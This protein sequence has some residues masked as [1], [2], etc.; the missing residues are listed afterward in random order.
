MSVRNGPQVILLHAILI[1]VVGAASSHCV[2]RAQHSRVRMKTFSGPN[3]SA[4]PYPTQEGTLGQKDPTALAEI[5]ASVTASLLPEHTGLEVT[6]IVTTGFGNN[7]QQCP[8]SFAVDNGSRFRLDIQKSNGMY[9]TRINGGFGRFSQN[10]KAPQSLEDIEFVNPLALPELLLE[11]ANR[12]DAAVIDDGTLIVDEQSLKK[13]TITLFQARYGDPV[14]ASFYFNSTS[15]LLEKGV[16]V[17]HSA[18]D[19]SLQY[20]KV[21]TYGDYRKDQSVLLPHLYSETI[22]GQLTMSIK[23]TNTSIT[24]SHDEA[25]FSF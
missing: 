1:A 7:Q 9:S 12:K 16:F 2:A 10:D 4:F 6:G 14:S 23:V 21:M 19:R 8:I 18:G 15:N 3:D 25:Y 11:L 17:G 24:S 22:D 13:V 5:K 20:L